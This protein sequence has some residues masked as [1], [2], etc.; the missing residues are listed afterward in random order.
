MTRVTGRELFLIAAIGLFW[1]LNWPAV[2]IILGEIPPWTLRAIGFSL[3]AAIL[4][5]IAVWRRE[6]LRPA[7]RE[8]CMIAVA[9]LLTVFGF[10]VLTAFGQLLTQTSKAAI[11]AFTMPVW[12][13]LFAYVFLAEAFTR[14]RALALIMGMA[15]LVLLSSEDIPA[16]TANPAGPLLMLGSAISWA[17]G[18][19]LLKGTDWTLGPIA[20]AAWM[21]G[22]SAVP[23]VAMALAIDSPAQLPWPSTTVLATLAYHVAFPM[24]ACYVAWVLLVARLPAGVA[25][26]GTLIIPV[27]GVLSAVVILGDPLTWQRLAALALVLASILLCVKE[28]AAGGTRRPD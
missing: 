16:F 10:N 24:V 7:P 28:P 21:V 12:A 2:K 3:G 25:A 27:V 5:A 14:Y 17:A 1:G 6:T 26:I 8:W 11:I 22:F 13:S 9:G 19:V 20:R 15:G 18:T 4:A 23:A